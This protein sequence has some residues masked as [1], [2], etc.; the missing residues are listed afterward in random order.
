MPLCMSRQNNVMLHIPHISLLLCLPACMD[1]QRFPINIL[2]YSQ[3]LSFFDSIGDDELLN[4]LNDDLPS[5]ELLSI[6]D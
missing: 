3:G 5:H 1:M 4:C 6:L 2:S